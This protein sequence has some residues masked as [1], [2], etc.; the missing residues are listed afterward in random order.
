MQPTMFHMERFKRLIWN[1]Q[2]VFGS[3]KI[4]QTFY[5]TTVT[6]SWKA[7]RNDSH[8]ELKIFFTQ[9]FAEFL[10]AWAQTISTVKGL[11]T[12]F[13][14]KLS[15]YMRKKQLNWNENFKYT[16]AITF[17]P[18]FITSGKSSYRC[19]TPDSIGKLWKQIKNIYISDRRPLW[20]C[21]KPFFLEVFVSP[22]QSEILHIHVY[23]SVSLPIWCY[24]QGTFPFF[25]KREVLLLWPSGNQ[26]VWVQSPSR[27][28]FWKLFE[29]AFAFLFIYPT[30]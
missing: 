26:K 8:K 14:I 24:F 10:R 30:Y 3:K 13:F 23:F 20:N 2:K 28:N 15:V 7:R 12:F 11:E 16:S 21:I 29:T 6:S 4:A 19:S 22:W 25:S 5:G 17:I 27:P 18:H 9:C 1:I